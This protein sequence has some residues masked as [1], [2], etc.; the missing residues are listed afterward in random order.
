MAVG[1][2]GS[3]S[4][5]TSA[6]GVLYPASDS[7][8]AIQFDKSDGSTNVVTI[9]TTDAYVGIG[10]ATPGTRLEVNGTLK[11]D[12]AIVPGSTVTTIS[13]TS[14]TASCY[15]PIWGSSYK[16]AI[17]T[18]V[19]YQETSIAQTFTFPTSP[20]AF[21]LPPLLQQFAGASQI[22]CGTYDATANT[23]ALT[24]PANASMAAQSCTIL[25]TGR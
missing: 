17:C 13:G 9:D 12:G 16:M 1:S 23:T 18:L 2:V 10:T 21:T 7:T 11:V 4:I 24:L 5:L 25:V 6:A 15:A 19:S 14:G 20:G 3:G 22:H 8:T